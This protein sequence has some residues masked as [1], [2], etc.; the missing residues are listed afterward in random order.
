MSSF[1]QTLRKRR[2]IAA[3]TDIIAPERRFFNPGAEE[4]RRREGRRRAC[5]GAPLSRPWNGSRFR[6]SAKAANAQSFEARP[7]C[8]PRAKAGGWR[9][10]FRSKSRPERLRG[11]ALT[12]SACCAG[13]EC[14]IMARRPYRATGLP[15]LIG[16]RKALFMQAKTGAPQEIQVR[17]A[18]V[19]NLKNIDVNIRCIRSSALPAFPVRGNPRWRWACSRR[20]LAALSGGAFHLYAP[21]HDAIGQGRCGRSALYP[22]FAGAAPAA[23]RSRH[24]ST[25]GTGT[26]LLNSLRL[27]YSRLAN[28]VSPNGHEQ[29]P[30][31]AVAAGNR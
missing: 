15:P 26:E 9:G 8:K 6:E 16:R 25:F 4:R 31:L 23:R 7:G 17:G 30:T 28:H 24:R 22:R 19:H 14:A 2:R 29:A 13:R 12:F 21:A 1:G 11:D 10:L 3:T 5:F 20:G 27:M 18:R